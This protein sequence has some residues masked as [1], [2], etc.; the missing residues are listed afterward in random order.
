MTPEQI[1]N[2]LMYRCYEFN[3]Q[4]NPEITPEQWAAIFGNG[5][6]AMERRFQQERRAA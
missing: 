5:V 3:R 6:N 4:R 2:E 1:V